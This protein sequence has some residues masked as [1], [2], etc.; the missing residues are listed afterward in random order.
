MKK[1]S[2]F[3]CFLTLL[4]SF[5]LSASETYKEQAI[6]KIAQEFAKKPE[7][8]PLI[9]RKL[10]EQINDVERALGKSV[11][12]RLALQIAGCSDL[13]AHPD[14]PGKYGKG[15]VF[16][17]IQPEKALKV[18][19]AAYS[20][21]GKYIGLVLANLSRAHNKAEDYQSSF[22][23][24]RSAVEAGY[25]FGDVMMAIHYNYGDG[26]KKDPKAQFQWYKKAAA[27]GI[28]GAMRTTSSNYLNGT[29]TKP[30]LDEAYFW[31]LSAIELNDGKGFYS[32]GR[33]LEKRSKGHSQPDKILK[34]ARQAFEIAAANK[35]NSKSEIM[36]VNKQLISNDIHDDSVLFKPKFKGRQVNGQ[37]YRSEANSYWYAGE[38]QLSNNG[39]NYLYSRTSYGNSTLSIWYRAAK[40]SKNSG[41]YVDFLYGGNNEIVEFSAI[42]VTSK[43]AGKTNY[44]SLDLSDPHIEKLP[45]TYRLTGGLSFR[46][47]QLLVHGMQLKLY[48][49]SASKRT[50][51]YTFTLNDKEVQSEDNQR[52]TA[53]VVLATMI[54]E[55]RKLN[56]DCC[57]GPEITP[58]GEQYV[59]IYKMCEDKELTRSFSKNV[60]LQDCHKVLK[61]T[62]YDIEILSF[63]FKYNQT[64]LLKAI[65]HAWNG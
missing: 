55:A 51:T 37:F 29:G 42:S 30:N 48:Y 18:C 6:K 46:D 58:L 41:W 5:T 61:N 12:P 16:S 36:G 31:A 10:T 7:N 63:P 27:K 11:E 35:L 33:V 53:K 1:F 49:K 28:P 24:A 45:A 64:R 2:S 15:I 65:D 38:S 54:K 47:V 57:A 25:P 20:N 40:N 14:D 43:I 9:A 39:N 59:A 44:I 26:V 56:K 34:L 19:N 52:Q 8:I 32:M 21:G 62:D 4:V 50:P 13:A 17:K 22:Y 60:I 3:L 23:Y